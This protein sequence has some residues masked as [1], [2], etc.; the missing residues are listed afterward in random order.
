[1]GP[2]RIEKKGWLNYNRFI[3][4]CYVVMVNRLDTIYI[5]VFVHIYI[6]ILLHTYIHPYRYVHI[7]I[8]I[9]LFMYITS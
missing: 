6:H 3:F 4:A 1:M 2:S 5:F 8:Y 7:Y 9:Y